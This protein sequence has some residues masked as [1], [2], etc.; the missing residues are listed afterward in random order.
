MS[1]IFVIRL[2]AL[3]PMKETAYLLQ[4]ALICIWWVGLTVSETFF[5]AFQFADVSPTAFWGFFGPDILLIATLSLVR[6]YR[7]HPALEWVVLG[8]FGYAAIYCCNVTLLTFTGYLPSGLMLV[9]FGYNLFLCF[10]Q[11]MFRVSQSKSVSANAVKTMVQIFCIWVMSLVVIPCVLMES[12]DSLGMPEFG[13]TAAFGIASLVCFSVLG[14]TSSV[15]MVRDGDG[16]PLPLDQTNSL[17][18]TGPYRYVR[19]P[20]AIAGIG[21]GISIAM[22]FGS[23]PV[24][25]YALLGAVVWHVV[26]RPIEER[27]MVSRFGDAYLEYRDRVKCWIPTF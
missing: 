18:L 14:L 13:L 8:A 26:V 20:M 4:A 7:D 10:N 3:E 27:D 15:F 1:R 12:F 25:V 9:G 21:Q 2:D 17:V 24:L 5:N 19:N 23:M 16:T 11:A 22:I 6:A